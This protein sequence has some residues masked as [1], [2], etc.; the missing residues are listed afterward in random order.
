MRRRLFVFACLAVAAL[1]PPAGRPAAQAVAGVHV[2]PTLS[3]LYYGE[4]GCDHCDLFLYSGKAKLEAQYGVELDFETVDIL[5]A[6]GYADCVARLAERGQSFRIW[7]VL[8][9]GANAYQGDAAIEAALPDEIAYYLAEGKYRPALAPAAAARAPAAEGVPDAAAFRAAPLPVLA[10]GLLDG[11]N[12]CAFSTLLFLLSFLTL[13]RRGRAPVL[14]AG[15]AF[16]AAVFAVYTALGFGLLAGLRTFLA[17]RTPG[18]VFNAALSVAALVLGSLSLRD[19]A[20]AKAGRAADSVLALPPALRRASHWAIRTF[21][22]DGVFFVGA[23]LAGG[24]VALLELACTGQIYFP[25]LA[26]INRA[27]PDAGSLGLLLLYNAA[28]IAPLAAVFALFGLGS[29]HRSIQAWYGRHLAAVRLATGLFFI[30][31]V[32]LLWLV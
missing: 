26:Y 6:A 9:I 32:P 22:A 29:S 19:A 3:G 31:M 21:A 16:I 27:A 11:V 8:L 17:G 13:R 25:T 30:G 1:V 10:A 4:T 20:L 7:P 24:L 15:L 18:L 5:D 14:A 2:P 12:P 28:F 23:A